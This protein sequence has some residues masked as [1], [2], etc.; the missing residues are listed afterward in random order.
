MGFLSV[1]KTENLKSLIARSIFIL[2]LTIFIVIAVSTTNISL[3]QTAG[4]GGGAGGGG[5]VFAPSGCWDFYTEE[6][7]LN[8]SDEYNCIWHPSTGRGVEGWCEKTSFKNCWQ[9]GDNSSCIANNCSWETYGYC[10]RKNCWDF[11]DKASCEQANVTYGINCK[12]ETMGT[13]DTSDDYCYEVG[14][15][16]YDS[17]ETCS[18][19]SGCSWESSGGWCY[20]KGCWDY[21]TET[22]CNAQENCEWNGGAYCRP[23][24]CW[25]FKT[26]EDC[27]NATAHPNLNCVWDDVYKYCYEIGCWNFNETECE[28]NTYNLTCEWNSEYGY[29]YK[30]SCYDYKTQSD[31]ESNSNCRWDSY[32]GECY[33][34]GCWNFYNQDDCENPTDNLNCRWKKTGWCSEY[35]CWMFDSNESVCVNNSHNLDCVWLADEHCEGDSS[36]NCWNYTDKTN[37]INAGC[38][39]K[40]GW[41]KERS[42]WDFNETTCEDSSVHPNLNCEWYVSGWCSG[43]D[44]YNCWNYTTEE[45]CSANNCTWYNISYCREKTCQN[46]NTKEACEDPNDNLTCEWRWYDE[47][48]T[49]GECYKKGCWDF[50]TN[51]TCTNITAHPDLNCTWDS[52]YGYCYE[53]GCWDY[54]DNSSCVEHGCRWEESGGFCEENITGGVDCWSLQS[55]ATCSNYTECTWEVWGYCEDENACWKQNTKADCE[56]LS[57]TKRCA[58]NEEEGYCYEKGCW[59]YTDETNCTSAG[60]SWDSVN[61]Y[62][63][64]EGCW[65]YNS[66]EDCLNTNDSLNCGWE[67]YYYCHETGCWDYTN[68]SAC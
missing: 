64:E 27:L 31:C 11:K 62:C 53:P 68:E 24:S 51:E 5:V 34:I 22:T 1:S 50:T 48:N 12:W 30:P 45:T 57:L 59:E 38:E 19:V 43:P 18:A 26:E 7:C 6:S 20:E 63:Y 25:D 21:K 65:K 14:C 2:I 15:W 23:K 3:A 56:A 17:N 33:E 9:Y 36:L 52:T 41:C 58:W 28:N 37:C 29:C 46:Y 39:W 60:C 44:E 32:W 35:G 8:K 10:S 4:G 61:N 66:K 49:S 67:E 16:I 42:C 54:K 47:T 40:L 55:N 13:A